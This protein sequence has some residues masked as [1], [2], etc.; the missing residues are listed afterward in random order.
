MVAPPY[1][2]L[3]NVPRGAPEEERWKESRR[4]ST[5]KYYSEMVRASL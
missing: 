1:L 4:K 5:A 2:L 3:L